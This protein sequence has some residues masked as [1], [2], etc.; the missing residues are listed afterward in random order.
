MERVR[1]PQG[2][3]PHRGRDPA[4]DG[5]PGRDYGTSAGRQGLPRAGARAHVARQD[6]LV[7]H[8]PRLHELQLP[9]R[10]QEVRLGDRQGGELPRRRRDAR[11]GA[12]EG[13]RD[14]RREARGRLRLP[15]QDRGLRKGVRSR[16]CGDRR[17]ERRRAAQ[18][19]GRSPR[20]APVRG[21]CGQGRQVR[22]QG[23]P[24]RAGLRPRE[25]HEGVCRG[26]H[27]TLRQRAPRLRRSEGD[28][29]GGQPRGPLAQGR[30]GWCSIRGAD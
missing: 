26:V 18:G 25:V 29:A 16:P 15:R 21:I 11:G 2:L 20:G 19:R 3:G 14:A 5:Q 28:P 27:R 7:D 9:G 30:P 13:G 17:R 8:R 10:V 4:R 24:R 1:L 12:R 6:R 22:A 23:G